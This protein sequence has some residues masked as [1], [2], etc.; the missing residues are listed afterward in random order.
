[1][2]TVSKFD[3]IFIRSKIVDLVLLVKTALGMVRCFTL[4]ILLKRRSQLRVS[5]MCLDYRF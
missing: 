5:L 1:M 2:C 4:G 3:S